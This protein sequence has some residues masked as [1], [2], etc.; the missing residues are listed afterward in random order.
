M[1]IA[2]EQ[3][4]ARDVLGAVQMLSDVAG[5]SGAACLR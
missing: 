2:T 4:I 3:D 1:M 5:A